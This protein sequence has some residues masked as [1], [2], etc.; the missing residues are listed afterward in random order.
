MDA[1]P[2]PAG[3]LRATSLNAGRRADDLTAAADE[4]VDV[5]VAGGGI[6]GTGIAL[7]AASRGLSAVLVEAADLASGASSGSGDP[8]G[9]SPAERGALARG[10]LA[11]AR[12]R[13]AER[14]FLMTRTAPHLVRTLPSLVPLSESVPRRDELLLSAG[15][16][17]ED[18]L[19][20]SARTPS[21]LLPAPRRIPHPEALALVPGI[22]ARGLRGG[23]LSFTGQLVDDAR[24]AV[25]LARTAAGFG[26]RVLT[27]V[28]ADSLDGAG[29]DLTDLRSGEQLRVRARAVVNATG[30]SAGELVPDVRLR[31]NH[32]SSLLVDADAI[33][34]AGTALVSG[35]SANS[36]MVLPRPD[37][38]AVLSRASGA[39]ITESDVDELLERAGALLDEP[40]R[41]EHVRGRFTVP[42]PEI[43]HAPWKR[44]GAET[45]Q[46]SRD[47]VLTAIGGDRV[48]YRKRASHVVDTAVR[49]AGLAAG[50]SRTAEIPL[51]GGATREHLA[52][53]GAE[54]RLVAKY[55]TEAPRVEALSELDPDLAE[56]VAPALT[57]AEVVWAVRHEGALDAADVLDRR[58]TA[59]PHPGDRATALPAVTDLVDRAL[60]GVHP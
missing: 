42:R 16:R 40:P 11:L 25:A 12:E 8:L 34:I 58:G 1:T 60:H 18:A 21:S 28:R 20:L 57:A 36:T 27:R 55:G 45:I 37:G 35:S 59:T 43:P 54:P 51:V 10:Q 5:L 17:L 23:L 38:N 24:L 53:L 44:S 47:G 49:D 30:G 50:P 39:R 6:T 19:R 15:L 22:R 32:E 29:A 33:G 31:A 9:G 4:Q 52:Q 14:H 13:A 7:D 56:H 26:A 2:L 41:R 3:S 46:V 48:L